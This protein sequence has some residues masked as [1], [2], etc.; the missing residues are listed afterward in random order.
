M[1]CAKM[2]TPPT[3]YSSAT[4]RMESVTSVSPY[5]MRSSLVSQVNPGTSD[6]GRTMNSRD[7]F[8]LRL[9]PEKSGADTESPPLH[10]WR[11]QHTAETAVNRFIL[12]APK[13][14]PMRPES[15]RQTP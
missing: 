11:R 12:I 5:A 9:M 6:S 3:G 15:R 10:A 4:A 8:S 7:A 2:I 1:L 14:V 13:P